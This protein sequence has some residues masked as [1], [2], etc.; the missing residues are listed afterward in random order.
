MYMYISC[1]ID[2]VIVC[3]C[4]LRTL[5][6]PTST[7]APTKSIRPENCRSACEC[8]CVCVYRTTF[9]V[10]HRVFIVETHSIQN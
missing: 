5:L 3:M 9:T 8:V 2:D 6:T 4:R 10:Y 7:T 1:M